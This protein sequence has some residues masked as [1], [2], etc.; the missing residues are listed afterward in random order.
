MRK[1]S[2]SLAAV[3]PASAAAQQVVPDFLLD[4]AAPVGEGWAGFADVSFLINS[5]LTLTLATLLGA[6]LA[7]HP[8]LMETADTLEEID[9]RKVYL[10][11]AVIG[12]LIGM[13]VVKY[14]L[15]VGFV[16]FGIG[17]L[18]RFRT[19]L[20]SAVLTGQV[21]FITLIGLA[22]GLDLPHVAVLAT[23]FG[24]G[25]IFILHAKVTYQADIRDLPPERFNEA[26]AAYRTTFERLGCKVVRE[27][28]NASKNRL[29]FIFLGD[30]YTSSSDLANDIDAEIDPALRGSIDWELD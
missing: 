26:A 5:F 22:C 14:G 9:A 18:I 19:V 11:Y 15:V 17:G 30:H 24:F 8:R 1:A 16:L 13:L 3:L 27:K 20:G 7:Y 4:Q 10:L 21:I 29:R 2:L 6:A 23:A 28:K 12:A 25:L